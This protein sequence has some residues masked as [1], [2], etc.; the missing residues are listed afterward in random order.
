[1][2]S[3]RAVLLLC[4]AALLG[5][6]PPTFRTILLPSSAR[7]YVSKVLSRTCTTAIR[8]HGSPR[9][10]CHDGSSCTSAVTAH[11]VP[12]AM[13]AHSVPSA[14][15]AHSTQCHDGL[16]CTSAMTA[17]AVPSAMSQTKD[18]LRVIFTLCVLLRVMVLNCNS[19]SQC[20]T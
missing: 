14:M 8:G 20:T 6:P 2:T 1:M 15:T 16:S 9:T 3:G 17:H 10:Q 11:P 7:A 18:V 13:T 19:T 4:E 5:E 12:S